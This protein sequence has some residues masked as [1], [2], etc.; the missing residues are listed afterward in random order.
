MTS[1]S[2]AMFLDGLQRFEACR[3]RAKVEEYGVGVVELAHRLFGGLRHLRIESERPRHL[4]AGFAD[5]AVILHD[6]EVKKVGAHD[7]R[8][9]A[10]ALDK[11]GGG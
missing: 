9:A 4:A 8:R 11:N 10:L 7:L 6:Q 5:G 2:G 3:A 1:A